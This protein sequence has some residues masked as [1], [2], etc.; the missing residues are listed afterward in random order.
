MHYLEK[1][2]K[3]QYFYFLYS[4]HDWNCSVLQKES[5]CPFATAVARRLLS[6]LLPSHSS[7]QVNCLSLIPTVFDD[8][9]GYR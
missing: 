2:E 5:G 9:M 4:G 1:G 7:S 6:L 8:D 3:D